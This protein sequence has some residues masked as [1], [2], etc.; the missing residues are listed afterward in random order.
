MHFT[1]S[2]LVLQA[3]SIEGQVVEMGLTTTMLL[4]VEKFPVLVPNSLFS[5]Q[6]SIFLLKIVF[7]FLRHLGYMS[8]LIMQIEFMKVVICIPSLRL[9][10]AFLR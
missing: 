5:S 2:F 1:Y 6:V 7:T 9:L 10:G 4:N 3:G 8:Y